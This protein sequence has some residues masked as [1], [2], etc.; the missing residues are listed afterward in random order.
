MG[1]IPYLDRTPFD[2]ILIPGLTEGTRKFRAFSRASAMARAK[3]A[4]HASGPSERKDIFSHLLSAKDAETGEG[5]PQTELWGEAGTL[6]AASSD[7]SSTCLAATLYYLSRPE[8]RSCCDRL[9]DELKAAFPGEDIEQIRSG[10]QLNSCTYLRA[11]IDE[12]LRISPPVPGLLPREVLSGGMVIDGQHIPAGTDIGVPLYALH[13]N[14]EYFTL[15]SS[16][17]PERWLTPPGA[18]TRDDDKQRLERQ[19]AA[20]AP[21]LIGPRGC[22][23]KNMAYMEMLIV[24]ARIVWAFDFKDVNSQLADEAE[25]NREFWMR[26]QFTAD[27]EGPFLTFNTL[28][29]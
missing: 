27:K 21:F 7:T 24:I 28:T 5:L 12:A 20:F 8:N 3:S 1:Q 25:C 9:L 16:Y 13:H 23:G 19:Q 22:I 4:T 26:D 17:Q 18:A 29:W 10:A 14:E 11:C 6:I 15:P 2:R